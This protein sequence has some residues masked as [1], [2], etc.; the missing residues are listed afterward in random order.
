MTIF[1]LSKA[2]HCAGAL[3]VLEILEL[4]SNC[5]GFA[6]LGDEMLGEL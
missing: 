5:Q 2:K 4:I 1:P 6:I 3:N